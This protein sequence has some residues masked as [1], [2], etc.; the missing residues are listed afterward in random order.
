MLPDASVWLAMT[1]SP[2]N[3]KDAHL[4]A[5]ARA[6]RFRLVTLDKG[7]RQYENLDCLILE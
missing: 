2:K 3:W 1:L 4:S 5:F 7:F 6:A